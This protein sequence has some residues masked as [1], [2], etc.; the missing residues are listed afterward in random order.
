M[1]AG[2]SSIGPLLASRLGRA[3]VDLDAC[4]ETAAAMS[5][6]S[7]FSSEGEAEFRRR[8]RLALADALAN[9][10]PS[11]IATGG[12]AVLDQGNRAAMRGAATVVCLEVDPSMQLQRLAG[13]AA[14]PL[15][16]GDDPAGRLATLRRQR[17]ALYREAAHL[18]LDTSV[19][20]PA[21][22]AETLAMLLAPTPEQCA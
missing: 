5:I 3:F 9:P 4:I 7:I 19:H 14:R 6:A 12:G 8:E 21:S 17:E 2:K 1:G 10:A 13:D 20:T 15:L 11:V 18:T 16:A 22:A